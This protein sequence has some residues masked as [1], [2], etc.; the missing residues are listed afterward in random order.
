MKPSTR[1]KRAVS[2]GG[3]VHRKGGAAREIVVGRR[4]PV[5]SLPKGTPERG[6]TRKQTALREVRE[7]TGLD[8]AI[9]G[10]IGS[11]HYWFTE[12][13]ED[14]RYSKTVHFYLMSQTGGDLSLHDHEFDVVE[15]LPWQDA[16]SALTYESEAEIVRKGLS[17]AYRKE[18]R[19]AALE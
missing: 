2:V 6:E 12:P 15:W 19:A 8:V 16:L 5:C 3:V 10:L 4:G 7:E 17:V 13:D 1:V 11:I 18:A 14:A 9:E